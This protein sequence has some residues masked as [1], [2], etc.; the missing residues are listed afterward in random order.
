M[1]ELSAI[2]ARTTEIYEAEANAWDLH[3]SRSLT[4]R[5]WLDKFAS[6]INPRGEILDVGCGGGEPIARYFIER[7]FTLTG[8]DAALAMIDIAQT[9]FPAMTWIQMDMRELNLGQIFDGIVAWDSFFHLNPEEQR[10]TLRLFFNHLK[11][12]GALLLTVGHEAGEVLGQ[13]E[14]KKVYHSSLEPTEYKS[15]LFGA[16]FFEVEYVAQDQRCGMRSVI[17][18][19]H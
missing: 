11:P 9:R 2:H 14:G 18:A 7:N 17:L 5:P 6:V 8:I 13:V 12:D 1:N 16:G 3:R 10:L 15:I 4:E 19:H